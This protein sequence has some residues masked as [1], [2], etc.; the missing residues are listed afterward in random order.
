LFIEKNDWNEIFRLKLL[1]HYFFIDCETH[2]YSLIFIFHE[3]KTL[4]VC[5]VSM[6]DARVPRF[7]P[8]TKVMG[9]EL[10]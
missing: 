10:A 8:W 9:L 6:S 3:K 7:G 4:F 2:F 5:N 1:V